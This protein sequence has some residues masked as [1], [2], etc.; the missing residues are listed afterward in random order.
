MTGLKR[1]MIVGALATLHLIGDLVAIPIAYKI[2]LEHHGGEYFGPVLLGAIM[3]QFAMLSAYL[4][5]G[6]EHW[7]FR[8]FNSILGLI[9]STGDSF[10]VSSIKGL[11]AGPTCLRLPHGTRHTIAQ[12][13]LP[14]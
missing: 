14:A 13:E 6:T 8:W 4:A 9:L 5:W 2:D 1:R 3:G 10:S 7:I 12:R 11:F